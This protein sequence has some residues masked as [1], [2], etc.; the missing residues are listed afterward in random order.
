MAA[1]VSVRALPLTTQTV[2]RRQQVTLWM[3]LRC[4]RDRDARASGPGLQPTVAPATPDPRPPAPGPAPLQSRHR[5]LAV[6]PRAYKEESSSAAASSAAPP[7]PPEG[8][9][10]PRVLSSYDDGG[11]EA[12]GLGAQGV[13]GAPRPGRPACTAHAGV[14]GRARVEAAR[15]LPLGKQPRCDG[16]SAPTFRQRYWLMTLLGWAHD[17]LP[18]LLLQA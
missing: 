2:P 16:A 3:R 8:E 5:Q 1:L 17:L 12:G 15:A 7:P 14:P 13:H 10:L 4:I 18:L 9:E 11:F 6:P